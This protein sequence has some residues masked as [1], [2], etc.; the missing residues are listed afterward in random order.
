MNEVQY[1]NLQHKGRCYKNSKLG[2]AVAEEFASERVG[3]QLLLNKKNKYLSEDEAIFASE[4]VS[5]GDTRGSY[6]LILTQETILGTSVV[7]VAKVIPDI[8]HFIKCISNAFYT[9]KS[10]NTVFGG[11]GMLEPLRIKSM[12]SDISNHLRAYN[13]KKQEPNVDFVDLKQDC[14]KRIKSVVH[15]HSGN[16][17]E[18]NIEDCLFL[19]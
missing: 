13:K 15:H 8:G 2:P 7:D 10:K 5:D 14:L 11:I 12:T 18:C 16:H 17:D 6:K 3:R 1:V 19:K 4:V 9:F